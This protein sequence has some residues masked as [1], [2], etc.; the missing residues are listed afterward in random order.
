MIEI[1]FPN[2]TKAR[3]NK[4]R[5]L[6]FC[7]FAFVFS[8]TFAFLSTSN[9]DKTEAASTKDF[10]AGNI[11][12][13]AVM[14]DYNS[15]TVDQ[16][17]S[18]LKSKNSCNQSA[19]PSAVY[20]TRY[21]NVNITK[22]GIN[23]N[24]RYYFR[25]ASGGENSGLYHV[26]DGHFVCMADETINGRSAAYHIWDAAQTFKI[27][28][29]VLIVLL[30]K[31]QSLVTDKWP[32]EVQ[33]RAATGY[34]CPDS[35][36]CDSKYYGLEAQLGN[37]AYLFHTVLSG[38]WTNFPLGNNYIQYHYNKACGGSTVKIEN[39]AT[40]ALYRYTPYQP[41]AASL[42]AGYG[43]TGDGCGAYGNRN[44]FL[45]YTDWFG[46]TQKT[47]GKTVTPSEQ[48]AITQKITNEYNKLGGASKFGKAKNGLEWNDE[49]GIYWIEYEKGFIVGSNKK[50]YYESTGKIRNVW[51]SKGFE[52]SN[53][54]FPTSNIETSP[55]SGINWQYFEG[56]A[57]VGN[58]KYGYYESSGQIRRVWQNQRFE[59]GPLGFPTSSI[60]TTPSSGIIYQHY[61]GGA[62]VGNDKYGYYESRGKIREVWQKFGFEFGPLGFPTSNIETTSATG[63]SY[64]YYSGG[65][66]VGD[67]KHGY[68]ESRGKIREA[69]ANQRFEFGK[70]GFPTSN[71]YDAG[72][73]LKAQSYEH[74][75]IYLN[76]KSNQ[77]T[78]K[79]SK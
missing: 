66:I 58:D 44:F 71:I 48:S 65:A 10:R 1:C 25:N 56:G 62:I 38:G 55:E 26:K 60:Q 69:W 78:I 37:A 14:S 76:T 36:A 47:S 51:K 41:N 54:G 24:R 9:Q 7:V 11:I 18:F 27:N 16:I 72:A 59:F 49:T 50:G 73:N 12:S 32:Y 4:I 74:G 8:A 20:A 79:Y 64:Q 40:S 61:T 2:N 19:D 21:E 42:A 53:L 13:D 43:V 3:N 52:T 31:E 70:L 46:S 29:K 34:G 6:V 30:E 23:Y 28:P 63:I 67:D 33:Y 57:I 39:L 75:I 45:L 35:A 77:T 17:Q 68:Y 5:M 22:H 15:M